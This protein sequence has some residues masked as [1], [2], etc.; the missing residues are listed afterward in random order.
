M[1]KVAL[2]LLALAGACVGQLTP[3]PPVPLVTKA[4]QLTP[5]SN[6]SLCAPIT[7]LLEPNTSSAAPGFTLVLNAEQGVLDALTANVSGARALRE[8]G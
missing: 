6:V 1:C 5:F 8:A 4:Y 3:P 2:L 7:L